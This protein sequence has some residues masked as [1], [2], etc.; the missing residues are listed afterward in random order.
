MTVEYVGTV[1]KRGFASGSKSERDA[2]MLSTDAG[3]FLLRRPQGNPF[4][5][6]I[7]EALVGSR[8]RCTG[9]LR[10]TT[11]FLSEWSVDGEGPTAENPRED[12]DG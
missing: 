7:L 4:V 6:P 9:D 2:V 5:D 1:I 11:L 12:A 8:L 3:E 10:G